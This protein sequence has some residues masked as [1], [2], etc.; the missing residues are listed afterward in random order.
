MG[1]GDSGDIVAREGENHTLRCEARGHPKPLIVWR[2]ED[3]EDIMVRG[4]KGISRHREAHIKNTAIVHYVFANFKIVLYYILVS[5]VEHPILPLPKISR[6]QMGDYLCVASNGV[7]PSASKKIRVSVQCKHAKI[8]CTY[9]ILA[10]D[11]NLCNVPKC[12]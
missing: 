8:Q 5:A 2:R 10:K 11:K 3:G 6:L 1:N 4:R 7:M 9:I 12:S